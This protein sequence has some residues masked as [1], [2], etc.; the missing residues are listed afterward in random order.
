M[1]Y[2]VVITTKRNAEDYIEDDTEC[3]YHYLRYTTPKNV[4]VTIKSGN[5]SQRYE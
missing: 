5:G 2:I 4:R 3:F 1:K